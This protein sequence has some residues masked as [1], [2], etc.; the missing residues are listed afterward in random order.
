[1]QE[2]IAVPFP[3]VT[4]DFLF[5]Q[6]LYAKSLSSGINHAGRE[7]D[8]SLY[9]APKFRISGSPHVHSPTPSYV[10]GD[11]L[12]FFHTISFTQFLSHIIT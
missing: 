12:N 9:P 5:S 3:R 6:E 8:N 11:K 4:G 10:K 1:V 2:T 7:A